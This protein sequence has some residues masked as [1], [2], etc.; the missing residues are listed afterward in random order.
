MT[1]VRRKAWAV[2][3]P[4]YLRARY[5]MYWIPDEITLQYARWD[6]PPEPMSEFSQ[7]RMQVPF[8]IRC[9]AIPKDEVEMLKMSI[10]PFVWREVEEK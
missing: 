9:N 3:N 10:P 8:P 7:K 5:E 4:E 2:W 1:R 6:V